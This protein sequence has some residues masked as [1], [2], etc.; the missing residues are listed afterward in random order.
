MSFNSRIESSIKTK[1]SR[2]NYRK[3]ESLYLLDSPLERPRSVTTDDDDDDE[4]PANPF[5]KPEKFYQ[6]II[7]IVL[8]PINILFFFTVPDC[9]R[10][11]FSRFPLYF[12]TFIISTLYMGVFTY[13]LVWMVVVISSLLEI[14]DTVAGLT[15]LAAGTSIPGNL[16]FFNQ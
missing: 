13:I 9:R 7:W 14:P 16:L 1:L 6:K 2:Y 8:F 10:P 3:S 12:L 11:T 15:I 5:R 4:I